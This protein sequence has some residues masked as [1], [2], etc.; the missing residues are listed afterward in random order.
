MEHYCLRHSNNRDY[1]L[2]NWELQGG[3]SSDGPWSTLRRHEN[4]Q[5]LTGARGQI[6]DW[7]VQTEEFFSAFRIITTGVNQS[8][9]HYLDCNGIE[10]FG[11]LVSPRRGTSTNAPCFK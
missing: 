8:N 4:D 10:L 3:H 5:T 6:G 2:R 11:Q 1:A 7:S 9:F